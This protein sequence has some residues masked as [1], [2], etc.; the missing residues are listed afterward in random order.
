M[1]SKSV[2]YCFFFKGLEVVFTYFPQN[3]ATNDR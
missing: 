2:I 1:A 3:E